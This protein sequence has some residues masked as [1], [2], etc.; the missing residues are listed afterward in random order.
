[1]FTDILILFLFDFL[2]VIVAWAV[3]NVWLIW[4][5]DECV[6]TQT[7]CDGGRYNCF[8]I[9]RISLWPQ[10]VIDD[11]R[12]KDPTPTSLSPS[13]SLFQPPGRRIT[14]FLP[15]VLPVRW[16]AHTRT[17]MTIIIAQRPKSRIRKSRK[18]AHTKESRFW[19]SNKMAPFSCPPLCL[20]LPHMPRRYPKMLLERVMHCPSYL[21]PFL[22][23]LPAALW[24]TFLLFI[25]CHCPPQFYTLPLYRPVCFKEQRVTFLWGSH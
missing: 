11:P 17:H 24:N 6:W 9:L 16:I 7:G 5:H 21:L 10:S 15:H 22:L 18:T 25:S 4:P 1:M 14:H 8:W 13:L 23:V 20:S 3:V 12:L 2:V 19:I